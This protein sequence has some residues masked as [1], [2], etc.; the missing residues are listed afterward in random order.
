MPWNWNGQLPALCVKTHWNHNT[1]LPFISQALIYDSPCWCPLAVLDFKYRYHSFETY[2]VSPTCLE[3]IPLVFPWRSKC[4]KPHNNY[5]WHPGQRRRTE[6][7]NQQ[8]EPVEPVDL[9]IVIHGN[10]DSLL[11]RQM[12]QYGRKPKS[13]DYLNV[14][15]AL[16]QFR[17]VDCA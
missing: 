13:L 2:H 12:P 17:W 4:E 6:D 15:E 1:G 5:H 11:A 7:N 8:R 3:L 14:S 9:P 16:V 10:P